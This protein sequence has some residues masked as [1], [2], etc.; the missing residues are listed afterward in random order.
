MPI[1]VKRLP[2]DPIMI[3]HFEI[4][5]EQITKKLAE[6]YEDVQL[7]LAELVTSTPGAVYVL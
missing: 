1:T 3:L 4:G 6:E 2:D 7:A 5:K